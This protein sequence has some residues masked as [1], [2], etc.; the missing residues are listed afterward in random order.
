MELRAWNKGLSVWV[1]ESMGGGG[2]GGGGGTGIGVGRERHE[3]REWHEAHA[4]LAALVSHAIPNMPL[5]PSKDS[6]LP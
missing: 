2:G 4:P 3:G 5:T 1:F 6:Y